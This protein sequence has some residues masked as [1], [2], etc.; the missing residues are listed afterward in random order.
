MKKK[1]TSLVLCMLLMVS[2][3]SN[4][5]A[6]TL[7][8][9]VATD[10]STYHAGSTVNIVGSLLEDGQVT[11]GY[12][13][14]LSV[15][16][17]NG[18]TIYVT[19]WESYEM[20]DSGNFSTYFT[21]NSDARTGVYNV[22]VQASTNVAEASFIVEAPQAENPVQVTVS[23]N[24][25]EYY[26]NES[27]LINGVV[28][29]N[30]KPVSGIPVT[31]VF[32]KD[33]IQLK[34]DQVTTNKEGKYSSFIYLTSSNTVGTYQ[35]KVQALGATKET[36]FNVTEKPVTPPVTPPVN[37][38]V[39]P[40]VKPP[41]DP[42]GDSGPLPGTVDVNPGNGTAT[43]N[44]DE[45]K[46]EAELKDTTKPDLTLDWST[47]VDEKIK[48]ISV[49]LGS[50]SLKQLGEAKK[51]VVFK[52]ANE[53]LT[54]PVSA[55]TGA[56]LSLDSKIIFTMEKSAG[57]GLSD[58]YDFTIL[59]VKGE[60]K[61][62]ITNFND[63]VKVSI[64]MKGRTIKDKRKVAA[65]Y[66]NEAT[67]TW[68]YVGG[69]VSGENFEF[70]TN[71]FS[72]FKVVENSKTFSDVATHWAKDEIEVL[73]SREII[74]GQ[75]ADTFNPNGSLTRAQFAIL[76]SRALNLPKAAYQGKFSDLV[77]TDTWAVFEVEAA[78]RAGIITGR[79]DGTFGPNDKITRE[80]MAAM[81][82]RA[83]EYKDKSVLANVKPAE[84]FGDEAKITEYAKD[85]VQKAAGLGIL[86]GRPDKTFGPKENTSRAQA[87]VVIYRLL[88][89]LKVLE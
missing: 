11:K 62:K 89:T 1:L 86:Q 23:T 2:N 67:K 37:P 45:K 6:G 17:P 64:S 57:E 27:V 60:V 44:V 63:D 65:Y 10:S 80:Q 8:L 59:L 22:K 34:V 56:P 28:T 61:T 51:N 43:L 20:T 24:R 85:Y 49:E 82:V 21:L 52:T 16:D 29:E 74:K 77:A 7:T 87:A 41:V 42:P 53:S 9:A 26:T 5:F 78:F 32:S 76:M 46:L 25:A 31:A 88:S 72:Q 35:A 40:P 36:T 3:I 70:T 73:A 38:P 71:H 18:N 69:K 50:G 81:I 58:V 15:V 39:D 83:I 79:P 48:T 75:T 12:S 30:G 14:T 55:F 19:Q 47:V 54:L 13:P 84:A 68:E 4:V 66:F 33:G